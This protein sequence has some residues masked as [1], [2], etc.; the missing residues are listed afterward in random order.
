MIWFCESKYGKDTAAADINDPPSST[1]TK[2][3]V[4]ESGYRMT[5]EMILKQ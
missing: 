5:E 2:N 1:K 3:I 4:Y